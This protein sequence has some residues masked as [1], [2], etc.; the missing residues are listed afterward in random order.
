[1]RFDI[2]C[3]IAIL[4]AMP[5]PPQQAYLHRPLVNAPTSFVKRAPGL[6]SQPEALLHLGETEPPQVGAHHESFV[7]EPL[8]QLPPNSGQ[9]L[10]RTTQ[11]EKLKSVSD[12]TGSKGMSR[13]LEKLIEGSNPTDSQGRMVPSSSSERLQTMRAT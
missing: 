5:L 1:M 7:V 9:V 6:V 11:K 4:T 10:Q 2:D 12:S 3:C 13:A 8:P